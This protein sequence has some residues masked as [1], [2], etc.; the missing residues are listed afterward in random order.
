MALTTPAEYFTRRW[1]MIG[2]VTLTNTF[3][4][5]RQ[6]ASPGVQPDAAEELKSG[7]SI[8]PPFTSSLKY[9]FT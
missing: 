2:R 8:K 1:G 9:A 5:L 7:P 3:S 6:G 4:A